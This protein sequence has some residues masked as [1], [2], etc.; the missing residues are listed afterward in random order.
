M[1]NCQNCKKNCQVMFPPPD[2]HFAILW[3]FW[4]ILTI[5]TYFD[6]FW[7]QQFFVNFFL[8]ILTKN[9]NFFLTFFSSKICFDHFLLLIFKFFSS[10][11]ANSEYGK[12]PKDFAIFPVSRHF[13]YSKDFAVSL[14]SDTFRIQK[15]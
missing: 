1:S 4:N 2:Q 6:N 9:Y 13:P 12:C 15:I 8:T 14:F 7:F 5:L 10:K 11:K 3:K